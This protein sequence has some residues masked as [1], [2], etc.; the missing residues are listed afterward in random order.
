MDIAIL[1]D[2]PTE[3]LDQK[4]GRCHESILRSYQL[5][6]VVK[7]MLE[8]GDSHET[9]ISVIDYVDSAPQLSLLSMD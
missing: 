3:F 7:G 8:R 5:L 2:L 9:I 1:R 4:R 6:A